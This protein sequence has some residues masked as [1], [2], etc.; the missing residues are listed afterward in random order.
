MKNKM[1]IKYPWTNVHTKRKKDLKMKK[2]KH[3]KIKN[4]KKNM[5]RKKTFTRGNTN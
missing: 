4:K 3:K 2:K 5:L 1:N